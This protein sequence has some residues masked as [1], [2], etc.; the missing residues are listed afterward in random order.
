LQPVRLSSAHTNFQHRNEDKAG[1]GIGLT[2]KTAILLPLATGSCQTS[3]HIPP[4]TLIAQ[5]PPIPVNNLK[6]TSAAK[7]GAT[8]EAI[9]KM[10]KMAKEYTIVP[11][12]PYDSDKGPHAMG[13]KT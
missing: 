4:T 6:T 9:E 11:L 8:A 5:L 10:V 13:P 1:K 3:A 12:R 2:I 7:F